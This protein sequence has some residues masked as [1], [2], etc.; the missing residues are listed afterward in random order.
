MSGLFTAI[1]GTLENGMSTYVTNVSSALSSA[2]VPIVTT[3]VSMPTVWPSCMARHTR[4]YRLSHG[5]A[6]G[7]RDPRICTRNDIYQ[8]QVVAAVS[9]HQARPDDPECSQ[10]DRRR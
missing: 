9:G 2:L 10:Y 1:G 5:V 4:R 7:C 3:S 6:Q 8:Q